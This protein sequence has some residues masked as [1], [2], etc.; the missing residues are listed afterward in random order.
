MAILPIVH[1]PD[2]V[3]RRV[4]KPVERFDA[5]LHR[6]LDDMLET[7]YA[8]P[9]IG[10]AAVQVGEPIRAITIDCAKRADDE[11]GE[12]RQERKSGPGEP[13]F[14]LN[15]EIVA[16]SDERSVYEEGCLSIPDY[17]AEVQRPES[18][19]V[20]WTDLDG[21]THER[22]E[23]GLFA[24]CVQH[25]MDHLEGTLFIDHISRLRRDRVVKKFVK[26]AKEEGRPVGGE[27]PVLA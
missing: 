27:R 21:N 15:P 1:I 3:L 25:E 14:F 26:M 18:V 16:S 13:M 19:R 6:F 4:S 7:M 11:P 24:T 20:R 22:E 5:D 17:Y 8:A 12:E 23:G 9:G 2:P 10:L